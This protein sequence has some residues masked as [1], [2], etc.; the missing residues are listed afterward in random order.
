MKATK[1]ILMISTGLALSGCT[2][3]SE[4]HAVN[5]MR[6]ATPQGG[7]PFTHELTDEY[8]RLSNWQADD[9]VMWMDGA[10]FARKGLRAAKGEV[11]MPSAPVAA[12]EGAWLRRGNLGET[13]QIPA[14]RVNELSAARVRLMAYLDGGGR[15]LQPV[16]AA[17]AQ[18]I[19]DCWLLEEWEHYASGKYCIKEYPGLEAQFM[20][21]EAKPATSMAPTVQK[22]FQVFFAFDRSE[23]GEDAAQVIR[24]AADEA[25]RNNV[26]VLKLTGHTDS[27]GST[28]YNQRLSERRAHA[29]MAELV[30]DGVPAAEI[31]TIGDGEGGQLVPTADGVREPQNRRTTIILQ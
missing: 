15:T 19:Y 29:V 23:V 1:Y 10:W 14:D 2:S 18:G 24:K 21:A 27:S 12:P 31:S 5:D 6:T 26:I 11:V 4:I 13:V 3:F 30:K 17:H 25:K 9:H 28:A 20:T 22:N 8:R 7:T 16:K